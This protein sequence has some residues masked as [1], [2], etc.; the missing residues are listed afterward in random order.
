MKLTTEMLKELIKE[1]ITEVKTGTQFSGN[2]NVE[3]TQDGWKITGIFNGQPVEIERPGG[4]M[5]QW[6]HGK[7]PYAMAR[8]LLG[9]FGKSN[10]QF[11][12]R[13]PDLDDV[14]ITVNDEG[15]V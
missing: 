3:P 8:E 1:V 2:L 4:S 9:H 15:A 12:V 13:A 14:T 11:V 10:P 5:E 6:R 7:A